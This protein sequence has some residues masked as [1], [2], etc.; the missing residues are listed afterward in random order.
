V[1]PSHQAE[2]LKRILPAIQ[3]HDMSMMAELVLLCQD[4]INTLE[5]D[6]LAWEDPFILDCDPLAL[7]H[8]REA[9][10]QETLKRLSYVLPMVERII[11]F[12]SKELKSHRAKN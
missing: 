1:P 8:E 10:A 11:E 2:Q 12:S 5:V 3:S 9:S 6:W 4:Q 7:K